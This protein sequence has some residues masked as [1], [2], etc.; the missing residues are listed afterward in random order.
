MDVLEHVPYPKKFLQG[1]SDSM[2]DGGVL[3]I[4]CP[5]SESL[6]WDYLT[7]AKANPYWG[8]IEHFHN[9][10]RTRLFAL[11]TEMGF[12]PQ[13]FGISQR[14][15]MGMEIVATKVLSSPT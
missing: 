5:N 15:R 3:L 8:E 10:S 11:L 1:V 13:R 7:G 14:Y 6:V 2:E 9:F 4:S 12:E